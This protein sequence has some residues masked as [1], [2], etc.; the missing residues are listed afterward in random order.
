MAGLKKTTSQHTDP[1]R[2]Y[3]NER[4]WP[5][6]SSMAANLLAKRGAIEIWKGTN[7]S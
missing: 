3:T 1:K 6:V 7:P 2:F 4:H 5:A